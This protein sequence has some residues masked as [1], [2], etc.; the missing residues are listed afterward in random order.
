MHSDASTNQIE[1]IAACIDNS[2][3]VQYTMTLLN[4]PY[5]LQS[6]DEIV[7]QLKPTVPVFCIR[8]KVIEFTAKEFISKFPGKVLYAVKCNSEPSILKLLWNAGICDFD[9]ASIKEIELV[10]TL[11][12][13][14][15][16]HFMHPIKSEATIFQSYF[17]Y[18][19]RNFALDSVEELHKITRSTKDGDDLGS[20]C[21][22]PKY[23]ED[24]LVIAKDI[25]C[26]ADVKID[27]I[28]VGGGFPANYPGCLV[29]PLDE[30]FLSIERC[31]RNLHFS[32]ETVLWCEPGRALVCDACSV[33]VAVLACRK[34]SIYINDGAY[35]S[36][37]DAGPFGKT[38]Y[39]VRLIR[40]NESVKT[41]KSNLKAFQ[42]YGPTC[43][44]FDQMD[45]PFE[46][47]DDVKPGDYIEVG[48]TG[49]YSIAIRTRF[50]GF[51][52]IMIAFINDGLL[53]ADS[54]GDI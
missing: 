15:K 20:Q 4:A 50:N 30:F 8:P 46:L 28:D 12:P 23:Y 42:F 41:E 35:G 52:E 27:I 24:A 13:S 36:L 29:P 18:G 17:N 5:Q 26:Q 1:I 38:R 39:P 25:I 40:Q 48:Q 43:D 45:G 9:C 47:P 2:S 21:I 51:D 11:F 44:S 3:A 7:K 16:I 10:R 54:N 32:K 14:A 22:E 49:A 33:I 31:F 37:G 34:D 6:I 53:T 19:V